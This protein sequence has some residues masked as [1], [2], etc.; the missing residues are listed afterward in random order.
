MT[1]HL[2]TPPTVFPYTLAEAK[3]HLK[4]DVT[5]DDALIQGYIDKAAHQFRMNF[6][7]ALFLR[8]TNWHE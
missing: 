8:V 3:L 6:V 7:S 5:D 2:K 4:V 1:L